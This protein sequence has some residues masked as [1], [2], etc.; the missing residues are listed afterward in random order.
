MKKQKLFRKVALAGVSLLACA[1][2]LGVTAMP[3][4]NNAVA[5][6]T[7]VALTYTLTQNSTNTSATKYVGD[8]WAEKISFTN[9]KNQVLKGI[10]LKSSQTFATPTKSTAYAGVDS[11]AM[12]YQQY[13]T[14]KIDDAVDTSKPIEFLMSP[15]L[16]TEHLYHRFI[17]GLT[18]TDGAVKPLTTSSKNGFNPSSSDAKY[19]YW[20]LFS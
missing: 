13:A 6:A 7:D 4:A 14:L 3:D 16:S 17:M 19:I 12:Q 10:Q 1:T 11:Y 2:C 5:D 9:A 15:N 20:E 8:I 18:D